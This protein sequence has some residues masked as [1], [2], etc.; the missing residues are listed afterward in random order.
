MVFQIPEGGCR[1]LQLRRRAA[2]RSRL[3]RGPGLEGRH[4]VLLLHHGVQRDRI[5][6][7]HQGHRKSGDEK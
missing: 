4:Q 3:L 7:V 1:E 5:V 2:A 6:R